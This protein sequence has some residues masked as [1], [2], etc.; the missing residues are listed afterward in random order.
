MPSFNAVI[1]SVTQTTVAERITANFPAFL[2]H[3]G[4]YIITSCIASKIASTLGKQNR[5]SIS[6][7][8]TAVLMWDQA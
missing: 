8:G 4:I 6:D 7:N 1:L 5:V 2:P 3:I